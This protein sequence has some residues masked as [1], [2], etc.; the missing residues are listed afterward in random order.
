MSSYENVKRM[1]RRVKE[2][3]VV[4]I[5]T[6]RGL[7]IAYTIDVSRNGLMVGSPLPLFPRGGEVEL[8]IDRQGENIRSQVES[9]EKTGIITSIA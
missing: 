6:E 2:Q 5:R 8:V 9:Y 4:G 3:L 1:R 7:N